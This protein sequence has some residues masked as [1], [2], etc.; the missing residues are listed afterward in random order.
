MAGAALALAALVGP[1]PA[2][3]QVPP[4][5]ST[6]SVDTASRPRIS[7]FVSCRGTVVTEL[8][9]G[10]V[11]FTRTEPLADELVVPFE[12]AGDLAGS[13][14]VVPAEARFGAGQ[15]TAVVSVELTAPETG[16]LVVD[17]VDGEGYAVGEPSTAELSVPLQSGEPTPDCTTPLPIDPERAHQTIAVGEVPQ[18]LGLGVYGVE[19]FEGAELLFDTRDLPPVEA[20]ALVQGDLPPGLAYVQ[21]RWDGAATTPGTYRFGVSVCEVSGSGGEPR[22]EGTAQA[23]ITVLGDADPGPPAPPADAVDADARFTG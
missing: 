14:D 5:E 16:S 7:Q 11:I 21:D 15:D 6:V 3:S 22:C 1:L 9:P 23:E 19:W 17:L 12:V 8:Q 4:P 10:G 2:G 18:P 13:V 20:L